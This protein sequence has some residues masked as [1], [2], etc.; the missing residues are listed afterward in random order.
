MSRQIHG[1][2]P[3][4]VT[5][6]TQRNEVDEP[7]LRALVN[8]LIDAKVH[9]LVTCGTTGE[10]SMLSY[11]ERKRVT[12]IVADE[13]MDRIPVIE[14]VTAV[15]TDDAVMFA[16][17]AKEF[18]LDAVMAAP[19][20]Y[21]KLGEEALYDYFSSIANV[22]IPLIVYN[23]PFTTKV[24]LSPAFLV[25]LSKEYSNVRYVKE[26]S[27]DVRRVTEI[28]T[29]GGKRPE[30]ICGEDTLIFEFF[31]LGAVGWIST[32]SNA[33]PRQS[34]EM[35]ETVA[36]KKDLAGGLGLM[37][38]LLPAITILDGP[39]GIQAVKAGLKMQGLDVGPT[40]RPLM[41]L[42]AEELDSLR[43]VLSQLG[44]V[45]PGRVTASRKRRT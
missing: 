24:D 36:V 18:A 31:A 13:A 33:V 20:Y 16:K 39:K 5:P 21:F 4:I 11:E 2:I 7:Q 3:P 32:A 37:Y 43:G 25:K 6:F 40:R 45:N 42:N 10:F 8:F 27:G 38:E 26:S 41:P 23:N 22:G 44:L 14:G 19:S 12:E 34:V 15:A 1:V 9:G 29:L 35:Y 30:V 28:R 17:H